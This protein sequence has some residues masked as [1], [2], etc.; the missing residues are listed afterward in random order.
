MSRA[1][2]ARPHR[3][4]A[5][6]P[7]H[8]RH[9]VDA[10]ERR[11]RRWSGRSRPIAASCGSRSRSTAAAARSLRATRSPAGLATSFVEHAG[12]ERGQRRRVSPGARAGSRHHHAPPVCQRRADRRLRADRTTSSRCSKPC[13]C[14]SRRRA[15]APTS[16]VAGSAA[17]GAPRRA[18]AGRPVRRRSRPT[19]SPPS[20][21]A[22][23]RTR[24]SPREMIDSRRSRPRVRDLPRALRRHVADPHRDRRRLR[25]QRRAAA[26]RALPRDAAVGDNP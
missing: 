15:T 10:V 19:W 22:I 23:L 16:A 9:R 4:R 7:G 20:A 25:H 6:V 1:T 2:R 18:D 3:R 5:L 14:G 21:L 11:H 8:R 12:A 17:E 24:R 26:G 13:I